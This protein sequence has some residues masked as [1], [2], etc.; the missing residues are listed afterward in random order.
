MPFLVP[1]L[2]LSAASAL[3]ADSD[4]DGIP[5]R[6]DACRDEMETVNQ[7]RDDDGC[8]DELGTLEVVVLDLAG[9]EVVGE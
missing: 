9:R 4:R 3:A 8:P 1:I 7:F 6:D 5:N 2:A